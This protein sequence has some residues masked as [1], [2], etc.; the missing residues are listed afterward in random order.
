M[1][2]FSAVARA[3]TGSRVAA[4]QR[5]ATSTG[6][7]ARSS[8]HHGA[9]FPRFG[10]CNVSEGGHHFSPAAHPLAYEDYVHVETRRYAMIPVSVNPKTGERVVHFVQAAEPGGSQQ[11]ANFL[12]R[13][14]LCAQHAIS[15]R[16]F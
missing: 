15:A 9:G 10:S 12:G 2:P 6:T 13:L 3:T 7:V 11:Q 8:E 5:S 1:I 14:G 16:A 4:M